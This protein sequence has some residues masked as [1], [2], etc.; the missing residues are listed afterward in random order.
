VTKDS[1]LKPIYQV[2]TNRPPI[3]LF[4]ELFPED[5]SY[6]I[7][8]GSGNIYLTSLNIT[9]EETV[10]VR[11]HP[12]G[13]VS[14]L[15]EEDILVKFLDETQFDEGRS[16]FINNETVVSLEENVD[17]TA[18]KI[19]LCKYHKSQNGGDPYVRIISG[20]EYNVFTLMEESLSLVLN[21]GLDYEHQSTHNVIIRMG[22]TSLSLCHVRVNVIDINDNEP[23]FPFQHFVSRLPEN[24]PKGSSLLSNPIVIDKDLN[25]S[26]T[27]WTNS[28]EFNVD[29]QTGKIFSRQV[30]DFEQKNTYN[31]NYYVNDSVGHRTETRVSVLIESED[32]YPP[33]F[34]K[35]SYFFA[36]SGLANPGDVIG[37]VKATDEDSGPDG[38]VYYYFSP[39]NDYFGIDE[40][41]GVITVIKELD[42]DVFNGPRREKRSPR[43]LKLVLKAHSKRLNS[44]EA[45]TIVSIKI[46]E[47]LLPV[48]SV[49][50]SLASWVQGVIGSSTSSDEKRQQQ[51]Q[52]KQFGFSSSSNNILNNMSSSGNRTASS[53]GD[54]LDM[55]LSQ[56]SGGYSE[57]VLDYDTAATGKPSGDTSVNPTR[58]EISEKSHRSASKGDDEDV[59]I[60]MINEG[61]YLSPDGSLFLMDDDKLSQSS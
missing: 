9:R 46:E 43:E 36:M 47:S 31:F 2:E 58:S 26:L 44:L 19:P 27:F 35:N 29:S 39:K 22:S 61:S 1:L 4:F 23:E 48:A 54:N 34:Q 28:N 53:S 38:R 8:S 57:I 25:D 49:E 11:V 21:K 15:V 30:F 3:G 14:P 37:Q 20:N 52:F 51:Q 18:T 6:K 55:E 40:T 60:R 59:E 13:E 32:E 56:T 12:A 24:S 50:S 45:S 5:S 41:R 33:S 10:K 17:V 42:T 7:D 16:Y